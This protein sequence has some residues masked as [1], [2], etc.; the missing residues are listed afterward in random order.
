MNNNAEKAGANAQQS[1]EVDFTTDAPILQNPMLGVRHGLTLGSLFAGIGGFELGAKMSNIDTLWNCEIEEFNRL[2]LKNN[3]TNTKQYGDIKELIKPEYVDIISGGFPC[4]DISI[5][6]TNATGIKGKRSG[7]WSEMY[8][9]IREVRPNY[10][11][12]ENSPMLLVRGFEQVLFD[13]S[14]IGY[15]AEWQCL[16]AKTFG[17]CHKRERLYCIAYPNSIGRVKKNVQTSIFN[18]KICKA[19]GRELSRAISWEV[20]N[21]D[22]S[23]ICRNDD[24]IPFVV[25]RIKAMGNAVIPHIAHYLFECIKVHYSER[26]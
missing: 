21:K 8:R 6:N 20:S 18:Q 12:I 17:F 4:Q 7:L 13:L 10:V 1:T 16:S 22:N 23:E 14:E 9:V 5:A 26:W 15:D 19:S 25:D 24:G 3:F 2:K 11:I